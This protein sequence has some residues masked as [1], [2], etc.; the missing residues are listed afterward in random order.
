MPL[1]TGATVLEMLPGVKYTI[2]PDLFFANTAPGEDV[3]ISQAV[4][5]P[6][7]TLPVTMPKQGVLASVDFAFVGSLVVA[8]GNAIT[9]DQWPYNFLSNL[10]VSINGAAD[11]WNLFGIDLRCLLH[12]MLRGYVDGTDVFPGTGGGGDTIVPGTYPIYLTWTL[13]L[14]IDPTSLVGSLFAQSDQ[15]NIIAKLSQAAMTDLFTSASAAHA[16]I[17]GNFVT[18]RMKSLFVDGTDCLRKPYTEY[19]LRNS[20]DH[21]LGLPN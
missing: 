5:G 11:L 8:G 17:T 7:A 15:S 1:G 18:D 14:A 4:P 3:S 21:L 2:N 16:T 20:V 19:Q 13:P 6:G 12:A 10:N 9:S